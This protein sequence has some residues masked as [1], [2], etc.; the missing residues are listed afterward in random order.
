MEHTI[1]V[2]D[3]E[4]ANLRMIERALRKRF[5]IIQASSAEQALRILEKQTVSLILTDQRMPGLSGTELLRQS[6]AQHPDAVRMVVTAQ[7]DPATFIEA[8]RSAGAVRV[9]TKPWDPDKL[10]EIVSQALEKLEV[11]MET[12]QS[13]SQLREAN[14]A[15]DKIA[16]QP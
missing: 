7:S 2:V 13:L 4:P 14:L 11:M 8:I 9:I 16:R 10:I 3:D 5:K 6:R 15:L 12:R 1:L